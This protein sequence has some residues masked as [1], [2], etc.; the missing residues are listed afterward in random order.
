MH[1]LRP[2][3]LHAAL[4]DLASDARLRP[5]AGC[6]DFMVPGAATGADSDGILDLS[7]LSELRGI[8]W[9]DDWLEIGALTTF[10]EIAAS[11][12]VQEHFSALVEAAR[13][14]GGWQIQT[15]ATLGGNIANAS[16]AGDSLPVLLALDAELELSAAGGVRRIPYERFH[17]GYRETA[18]GAGELITRIRLPRPA[19]NVHQSFRKVGTRE[20]QAISKLSVALCA[21]VDD[22]IVRD[23]RLAAGSLG[24][25]PIRL[26]EVERA[27]VGRTANSETADRAAEIATHQIHPIDDVRSSASYRRWAF[28]R[29][30]RRMTLDAYASSLQG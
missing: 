28:A 29:I 16:P 8:R 12:F 20:A 15:R 19:P 18:L 21:R 5:M 22:G 9:N 27:V 3:S 17:V 10:A 25:T 4:E 6:T 2:R 30:V 24:P 13:Q 11:N 7:L 26:R 14:V 1:V 23:Y